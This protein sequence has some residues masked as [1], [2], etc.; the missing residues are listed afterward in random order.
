ML[1]ALNQKLRR[2]K[3]NLENEND[4]E[5]DVISDTSRQVEVVNLGITEKAGVGNF[6]LQGDQGSLTERRILKKSSAQ[7]FAARSNIESTEP[8]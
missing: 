3:R 6:M 8:S 1:S 4:D 2:Q 7:E 5:S